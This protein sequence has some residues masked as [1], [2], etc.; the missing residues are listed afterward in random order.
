[1]KRVLLVRLSSLGDVLHTF[2]AVTDLA[3]ALPDA[4][5][6]WVVEEAYV[7]LV[8]MHPAVAH[9]IPF[10]LRRWRR[11]LLRAAVWREIGAFRHALRDRAYDAVID[12]Q[13]LV[14]SAWVADLARGRV[15]GYSRATAREPLAAR[16]Y[17]YKYDVEPELH[18]VERYRRLLARALG[19]APL[20]TI[21]YG[22][23]VPPRPAFAPAGRYCV[24]L[25]STARAEKLWPEASWMEL[26]RALESRGFA[27][28]L[29][30]GDE[31]ERERAERLAR[32][33]GRAVVAPRL[34]L[35][36]AAGLIGHAAAVVGLDTG[37]MHLGVALR[38][39][40]VGIFCN[41]APARTGPLGTG[42]IAVRGG[43]GDPPAAAAVAAALDE[44]APALA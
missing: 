20:A 8:R 38:T 39:P 27:C 13:G 11:G 3:R 34:S 12:A 30:W 21:D 35:V 16:F 43:L 44:I 9:A 2:P 1:M 15:H 5:L 10:A 19:Y 29:P 24:L 42:P 41:S 18:S 37:L 31:A 14:K 6:D 36:D 32:S 23:A 17:R 33:L 28:I 26:G 22:L 7:P 4:E 25:H 40:V